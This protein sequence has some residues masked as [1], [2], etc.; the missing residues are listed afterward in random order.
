MAARNVLLADDDVVKIA[1]FGLSRQVY[2]DCNYQKQGQ[3]ALPVKWMAI[4]SLLDR[5]FSSQ[6]DVWSFGVTLWEFFTLS[7]Q[8]FPGRV[9]DRFF[10]DIK[11][12]EFK[13][14][15]PLDRGGGVG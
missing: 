2:K 7:Q 8:P 11:Q 4:E 15:Y 3:E 5:V 12:L 13:F 9:F 14:G 6:S 10:I 1:D